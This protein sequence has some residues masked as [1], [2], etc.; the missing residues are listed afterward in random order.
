MIH[1]VEE[2]FT[3]ESLEDADCEGWWVQFNTAVDFRGRIRFPRAA[4]K[5]PRRKSSCGVLPVS[6]FPAGVFIF[7][8][9][10]Q[11]DGP[12]K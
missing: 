8:F 9:N 11:L 10:Q 3:V 6:L 4:S 7:H 5:P 2:G 1:E 12:L